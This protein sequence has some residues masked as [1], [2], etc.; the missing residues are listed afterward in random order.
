VL[1]AASAGA[2]AREPWL[3]GP[4]HG[5]IDDAVG[6]VPGVRQVPRALVDRV[7][8]EGAHD[9][10]VVLEVV[11]GDEQFD[12]GGDRQFA[13]LGAFQFDEPV[14]VLA[15]TGRDGGEDPGAFRGGRP[16]PGGLGP[17]GGGDGPFDV[18]GGAVGDA[19]HEF[20]VVGAGGV[21]MAA[22]DGWHRVAVDPVL[23]LRDGGAH[24]VLRSCGCPVPEAEPAAYFQMPNCSTYASPVTGRP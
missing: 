17:L 23:E 9:G 14:D 1:P 21:E 22:R 6:L 5:V 16:T 24:D 15:Y 2:M 20:A 11:G 4:F 13:A 8:G 19:E 3:R 10:A 12:A 18:L 7:A